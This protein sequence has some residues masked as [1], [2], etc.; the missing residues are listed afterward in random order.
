MKILLHGADNNS[1]FGDVLFAHLFYEKCLEVGF[2]SVDFVQFPKYGIGE[3]CRKE[4][5]YTNRMSIRQMLKADALILISG[6]YFG[7]DQNNIKE[8]IK[9]YI[10][11]FLP[12]LIFQ[13]TGKDVYILGVGGGPLFSHFLRKAAVKIWNRAVHIRVRESETKKYF[14]QYGVIN[15]IVITSDTAQVIT[16]DVLPRLKIENDLKQR[17]GNKKLILLHLVMKQENDQKIAE[18]IVP[19]L[20]RFITEYPDYGIVAAPDFVRDREVLLNLK[21]IE[22]LGLSNCYVYDYYDSWQMCALINRM[23][24]VITTKLHVGIVGASLGKSVLSFPAHREKT[25][26]YY[27]QIGEDGRCIHINKI[28]EN[29]VYDQFLK[30]YDKPIILSKEI[31]MLAQSNLDV[32]DDIAAGNPINR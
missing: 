3:F 15:N 18:Y 1:N 27:H 24:I 13:K 16:Q 11:Y 29:I 10:R 28:D 32:I 22:A 20:K 6:G 2:E 23:D 9:R 12:A 21:T 14:E 5:K 19:A 7:E 30:Y 26:R 17:F 4:L 31:R 8:T 25:G